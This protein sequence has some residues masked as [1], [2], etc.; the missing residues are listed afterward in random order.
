[1]QCA[2]VAWLLIPA[3]GLA[4][5]AP[6]SATALG[7]TSFGI[8][9]FSFANDFGF[10]NFE[11]NVTPNGNESLTLESFAAPGGSAFGAVGVDLN[12]GGSVGLNFDLS[13]YQ[14]EL[15]YKLLDGNASDFLN[16]QLNQRDQSGGT[17]SYNWGLG[18]LTSNFNNLTPDADGFVTITRD[19]TELPNPITGSETDAFDFSFGAGN[20]LP[21][22]D[23][24]DAD[25][26]NS[27]VN[28]QLQNPGE[29]GTL[30]M[31]LKALRFVEKEPTA[32]ARIDA[33]GW[34]RAYGNF[35]DGSNA[36]NPAVVM[37]DNGVDAFTNLTIDSTTFGG[38]LQRGLPS[39]DVFNGN[40][41]AIQITAQRLPGNTA[42]TFAVVV[43]DL[44]GDDDAPGAGADGLFYQVSTADFSDSEMTT[45]TIPLNSVAPGEGLAFGFD[46]TGDGS[47][48]EL[49]LY[50]FQL[51][52]F[53]D[54]LNM[55]FAS[56]EIVPF[57]ASEGQTGDYNGDGVVNAAD[58]T[59]F[60]D[61]LGGDASSA[62]AAGTRDGAASGPIGLDD[63]A[64]WKANFGE[65]TPVGFAAAIPEPASFTVVALGVCL[66][67]KRGRRAA[68]R[69][70]AG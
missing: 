15:T 14:V 48:D 45:V 1:M 30:I 42:A 28:I 46:N 13:D 52:L 50:E 26:P 9:A 55:E 12:I 67:V 69:V 29:S 59:V 49:N 6:R 35:V 33:G 40:E 25:G 7:P 18:D 21:D 38:L 4:V 24:V 44:D 47:I 27:L 5:S 32:L 65:G 31:E 63:Y 39:V 66:A 8:D 56:I 17:E 54:G 70:A 60:R 51:Q 11:M 3:V 57:T 37:R 53:D 36:L 23:V 22:F 34:N 19:L 61:N 62:F 58:Y 20:G 10:G 64:A 41:H 16:V 2:R 68:A 43:G